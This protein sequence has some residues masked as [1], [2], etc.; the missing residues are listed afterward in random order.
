MMNKKENTEVQ[1]NNNFF[2]EIKEIVVQ[3][4][5][6]AYTAINTAIGKWENASLRKNSMEKSVQ[7][8]AHS[9]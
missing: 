3:A 7:N 5:Q 9:Y 4:R 1:Y 2:K 8:M 6:K